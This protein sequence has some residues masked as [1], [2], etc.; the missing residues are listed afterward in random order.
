MSTPPAHNAT[1]K[2]ILT[3]KDAARRTGYTTSYISRLCRTGDILS[4]QINNEWSIYTQ[5]LEAFISNQIKRKNIRSSELAHIRK[6]EYRQVKIKKVTIPTQPYTYDIQS[7]SP[8]PVWRQLVIVGASL[9]LV[10]SSGVFVLTKEARTVTQITSLTLQKSLD[11]FGEIITDASHTMSQQVA[12]VATSNIKSY[13]S[14]VYAVNKKPRLAVLLVNSSAELMPTIALPVTA[15]VTSPLQSVPITRNMPMPLSV[16][17]LRQQLYAAATVATHISTKKMLYIST[18]GYIET[19]KF[20][21]TTIEKTFVG[22]HTL[23]T[24]SG[25]PAL[26]LGGAVRDAL[27]SAPI[28]LGN[29]IRH[30]TALSIYGDVALVHM[31]VTKMPHLADAGTQAVLAI[32]TGLS[33]V[34]GRAAIATRAYAVHT[35]NTSKPTYFVPTHP[36]AVGTADTLIAFATRLADPHHTAAAALKGIPIMHQRTFPIHNMITGWFKG[37]HSA[38]SVL[39]ASTALTVVL[40]VEANRTSV[41]KAN[42][43]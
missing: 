13:R 37:L 38:V 31:W 36:V 19:G 2:N 7:I 26:A 17:N 20:L 40:T 32:G 23:L 28:V 27:T 11:G 29:G 35:T 9:A 22:Y 18:N 6:S 25:V 3:V 15:T 42:H 30:A 8:Q 33:G 16:H 12:A 43:D 34:V 5:S 4:E 21:Y 24:Q 39:F 10:L 41:T 1:H 14:S